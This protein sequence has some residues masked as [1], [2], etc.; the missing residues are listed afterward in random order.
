MFLK[1]MAN[2]KLPSFSY[3]NVDVLLHP[4]IYTLKNDNFNIPKFN[5]VKIN[6]DKKPDYV[7]LP[8]FRKV[9][10]EPLNEKYKD[11]KEDLIDDVESEQFWDSLKFW[12]DEDDIEEDK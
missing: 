8:K 2:P 12:R 3:D 9:E 10:M 7:L 5:D 1:E 6:E 11:A 4:E